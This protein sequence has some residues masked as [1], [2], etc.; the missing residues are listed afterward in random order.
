[1]INDSNMD[2]INLTK[3]GNVTKRI[4]REGVGVSPEKG[5]SVCGTYEEIKK[6][7]LSL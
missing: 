3:D 6:G 2:L 1:M 5:N 4:L 7:L